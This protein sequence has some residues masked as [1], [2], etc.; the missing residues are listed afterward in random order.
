MNS[1]TFWKLVYTWTMTEMKNKNLKLNREILKT[2]WTKKME[3]MIAGKDLK[4]NLRLV[5]R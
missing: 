1:M 4:V 3:E 2:S 5:E